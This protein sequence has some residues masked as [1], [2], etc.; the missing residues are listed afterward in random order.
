MLS[1][2][3]GKVNHTLSEQLEFDDEMSRRTLALEAWTVGP[4]KLKIQDSR[5]RQFRDRHF[6]FS[7]PLRSNQGLFQDP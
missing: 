3:S 7:G 6:G 5:Q 4:H 2:F 1:C